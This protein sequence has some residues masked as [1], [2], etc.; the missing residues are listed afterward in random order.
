MNINAN[1][2]HLHQKW[3]FHRRYNSDELT[4]LQAFETIHRGESLIR[5]KRI[6][7]MSFLK[8]THYVLSFRYQYKKDWLCP[9]FAYNTKQLALFALL[10]IHICDQISIK[11]LP[12]HFLLWWIPQPSKIFIEKL[13]KTLIK[14][15]SK[16]AHIYAKNTYIILG[17][18]CFISFQLLLNLFLSWYIYNIQ[19]F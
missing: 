1:I 9:F 8:F 12:L 7:L 19:S 5:L 17:K 18:W 3:K 13:Y 2:I 11:K 16:T 15:I 6:N 14:K 10:N 4:F